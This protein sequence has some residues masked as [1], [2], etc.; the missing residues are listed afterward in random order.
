MPDKNC[1]M[2]FSAYYGV[3]LL[4]AE[5]ARKLVDLTFK[6]KNNIWYTFLIELI[7]TAQMTTC[8]Y[9]NGIII[10]YYGASGKQF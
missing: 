5:I 2:L 8:V 3:V 6:K 4:S 10:K 1:V 9:E 7:G